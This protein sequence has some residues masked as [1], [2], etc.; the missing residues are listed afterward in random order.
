MSEPATFV[1]SRVVR[2]GRQ[3]DYQLWAD[4][5]D[6]AAAAV[7]GHRG[8]VRL[9]QGGGF[10]HLLHRFADAEQLDRWRASPPV[11]ALLAAA[12]HHSVG[13]AQQAVGAQVGF[14]LP[15]EAAARKW[16]AWLVTW[17]TVLPV[18]LVVSTIVRRML[19]GW[20]P[21]AQLIASSPILTGLLTWV[22][23]PRVNRWSRFWQVQTAGGRARR[24]AN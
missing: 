13:R 16:K 22:I 20:P 21:P 23:L 3:A 7:P 15:S 24:A 2:P 11:V 9:E 5:F 19:P 18:L 8:G 4:A 6:R 10:H 14:A 1:L 12:E 17:L